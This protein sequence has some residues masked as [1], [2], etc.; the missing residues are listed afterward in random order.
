MGRYT[1]PKKKRMRRFGLLREDEGRGQAHERKHMSKKTD[2]GI[3]LEE[4]QKLKFLYGVSEKDLR[5][6]ITETS[7]S[8]DRSDALLR[9]LETRLDNVIYRLG[10]SP[11]LAHARQTVNHGHVSLNGRRMSIPSY[12]VTPG[13]Q[14]VVSEKLKENPVIKATLE[15]QAASSVPQ[16]LV[17]DGFTGKM[18]YLPRK[19]DLQASVNMSAVIDLYA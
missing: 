3:R 7:K 14:L 9:Y 5:R 6:G 13:E 18:V 1:G 12:H 10:F 19:E 8:A 16:W 11:T 2:Y 17:R 4:K 15:K